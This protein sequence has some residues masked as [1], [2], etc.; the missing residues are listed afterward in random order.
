MDLEKVYADSISNAQC[1]F[2]YHEGVF[3][4]AGEMVDYIFL[5]VNKAFEDITGLKKEDV[6]GK[7]FVRDIIRDE[8][9]GVQ[10]VKIYERTVKE[11]VPI[12]FEEYSK[13]NR[14]YFSVKAFSP[15]N[16]RFVSLI[17]DRTIEK[18]LQ[19]MVQYFIDN[20]G[21]EADYHKIA[22]FACDVSGA[23]YAAFNLFD[24]NGRDFTTV[25]LYGIVGDI[26]KGLKLLGFDVVGKRW[27]YDK[28]KEEKTRENDIT[29]F[30]SLADLTENVVPQ[31]I[32]RAIEKTFDIGE[33]VV[34][35]I[36]KEETHLG[37]FTL[38]FKKGD[39]MKNRDL[40]ALYLSELGLFLEKNRL[41]GELKT[42]RE[43]FYTLAE[44]APVGF[45]SCD[46]KGSITYANRKLLD[47]MDSPSFEVT[48][49]LNLLDL[50]NLREC[51]FSEQLKK[52]MEDD[53][54]IIFE[55][56]YKSVWNKSSWLRAYFTPVKENDLIVGSNI[57]LDD[58]TEKKRSEQELQEK[59]FRD[60]LTRAY[61]RRALDKQLPD[62]L[63]Q[64]KEK[65]LMGCIALLDI[66]N[67]KDIN[68]KF[69]HK[70]G[71][72]V[73][74]HLAARVL[75]ALR[76]ED[77]LIRT[78]GDE[79]LIYLHDIREKKN[80]SKFIKRIFEKI[81]GTYR[82]T[83]DNGL[84]YTLDVRCSL[85]VSFFP[86]DGEGVEILMS[87]ADKALYKVKNSGKSNYQ[88]EL[89]D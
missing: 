13:E 87:K 76:E 24:K 10:W 88:I 33:V 39:H 26:K 30:S 60:P 31:K 65:G 66:D 77:L 22:G 16:D 3:D 73:L 67:F 51:G 63:D 49:N 28:S 80:A 53:T 32:S 48:K 52:C 2:A 4:D 8:E 56:A 58:I 27:S 6:I 89:S 69:G 84:P 17:M 14:K 21:S 11:K 9:H 43:M 50:V 64:L 34:A 38:M 85:G 29:V 25:A 23:A 18:K 82:M 70:A 59:V 35:K 81:T 20:V 36:R 74:M 46:T 55:F 54:S 41:S 1:A 40:L 57:V 15:E 12:E 7:R 62:K 5:D 42:S 44:Y 83:D 75:K 61:N 45:L 71:D 72:S 86:A 47:L 68:D 79:F 37:D 78:G 19:E